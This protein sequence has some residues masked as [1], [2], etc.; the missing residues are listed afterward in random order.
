[1]PSNLKLDNLFCFNWLVLLAHLNGL[2][3]QTKI[4]LFR[5]FS[6]NCIEFFRQTGLLFGVVGSNIMKIRVERGEFIHGML[7]AP[8]SITGDESNDSEI[9]QQHFIKEG[10]VIMKRWN[11]WGSDEIDSIIP[12]H[13]KKYLVDTVGPTQPG[14]T[15][16]L[17]KVLRSVSKSRLP[18]H[19]MISKDPSLRLCR[20]RGQSLPDW[21]ALRYGSINRF[22]DGVAQPTSEE[23]IAKLITF[24]QKTGIRLIPYGGGTSVLG[25]IN[26]PM[27][28]N[29]ILTVDINN[30]R[31][32]SS[33]DEAS[34][35][36]TF[37]AGATGPHVEA[38]LRAHGYTLGHFPQS[39]EYSTLGGWIATR[40]IGQQ[41]LYYGRMEDMY[42]GGRIIAPVG[43]LNL[44]PFPTSAAG[45]DLRQI[46]LGSEGRLG[47]IT[48][49]TMRIHPLP[50]KENFYA[51]FFPD[52]KQGVAAV[53]DIAQ[54][55]IPLSLL[56]LSNAVETAT[57]L[58]LA[59]HERLVQLLHRLLHARG[60]GPEKCM[61]FFGV[62]G[63]KET[64]KKSRQLA[65]ELVHAHG[66]VH[67]GRKMGNE[68][69]KS[70]V[71]TPNIRKT[72]WDIGYSLDTLETALPWRDVMP[73]TDTILHSL[74]E[75][76][77]DI[78]E[79]V[80]AFAHISHVYPTGASI[81]VT[82]LYRLAPTAEETLNRWQKL[83]DAASRVI[84]AHGGTI[85]HQHGVGLDHLPYLAAEKGELGLHSIATLAQTFDPKGIMNPGKL[86]EVK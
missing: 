44:P 18:D 9:L 74:T 33:L 12:P 17:N 7:F 75:G 13:A 71:T 46:V 38:Q 5:I 16:D 30:F 35:L 47:I 65:L 3:K 23:E 28:D 43:T 22:P 21:I 79:R 78:G 80:L 59:G 68:W 26:P 61:L 77:R 45:P 11:G 63:N 20:A 39:F 27:S 49:A 6:N 1:M 40:S 58:K 8:H 82:Y 52:W 76:L 73:C 83:K 64:A 86:I 54:A 41:S 66:G 67:V 36:A 14:P 70:R 53:Q 84:V 48:E 4:H 19:S 34:R 57:T 25:H 51:A 24:A 56:R 37:G 32:M 31:R 69:Y 29:P 60:L 2:K 50:E 15:A 42:A 72:I 55:C 62:T 10:G 81:Y 85:S